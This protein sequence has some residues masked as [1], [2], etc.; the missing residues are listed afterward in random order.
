MKHCH[1]VQKIL[2]VLVL[3]ISQSLVTSPVN[4]KKSNNAVLASN[5]V[6]STSRQMV[7][8]LTK[9]R[10]TD[11]ELL[12]QIDAC[13]D[14]PVKPSYFGVAAD[15]P[16]KKDIVRLLVMAMNF[17]KEVFIYNRDYKNTLMGCPGTG[18]VPGNIYIGT[19]RVQ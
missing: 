15:N 9:I 17:K 4:A 12:F 2:A 8:K 14:N 7:G 6:S 19:V 16:D 13:S 18:R 5:S 1:L 3:G 11:G 10:A